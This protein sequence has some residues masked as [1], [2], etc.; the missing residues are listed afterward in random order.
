MELFLSIMGISAFCLVALLIE[1]IIGRA[2]ESK[3]TLRH[4]K[5]RS[6]NH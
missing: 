2:S 3:P 1:T 6:R 5:R 4:N